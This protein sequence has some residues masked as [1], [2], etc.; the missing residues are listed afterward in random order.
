MKIRAEFDGGSF[1]KLALQAIENTELV[2]LV[3]TALATGRL[4]LLI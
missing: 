1:N 3:C 4:P 2:R